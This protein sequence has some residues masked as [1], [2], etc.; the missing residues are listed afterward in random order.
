MKCPKC[1][2]EVTDKDTFCPS[3]NLRLVI[4]CPKCKNKVRLGSASCKACGYVFVKFCPRCNSANYV[5]SPTCRKCFY[6]FEDIKEEMTQDEIKEPLKKEILQKQTKK[7]QKVFLKQENKE[8]PIQIKND[9]RLEILIDF[10]NLPNIFKKFKDEEF[11]AKIL[12]NIKTSIKVAFGSAC[13]FYKENIARFKVLYNKKNN[14][15]YDKII[16]FNSEMDKLNSFLDETLN[17]QI[18]HKF[19]I[20]QSGEMELNKPVMQLAAGKEKDIITT[21]MAYE[22]LKD[23][24]S[25]VKISPDSYKMAS[26]DVEKTATSEIEETDDEAAI[27]KI[28]NAVVE[29]NNIKGISINS[30]RGTGKTY[31]LNALYK[32]FDKTD[33]A[34][35]KSR[36]SATSQVAPMG[37]FQNAFLNM[38]NLPT[39]TKDYEG[40]TDK[41][42]KMIRDYLPTTFEKS[43][44]E[45]LINL[46]YPIKEAFYETLNINKEKT[47]KDIKDILEIL[48]YNSKLLLAI[49]DFDLIDEMSFE[50]LQYLIKNNFFTDGSKFLLC[51][52]NQNSINMYIQ[53]NILPH[54]NCLDITLKKREIGSTRNFIKKHIGE[55]SICPRKISDQIIMNA[56]GDL[57]Y[58]G[59]VLYHLI[60]TK[61]LKLKDSKFTWDGDDDYFVPQDMAKIMEERLRFLYEKSK[62]QFFI[63]TLASFLGGCFTK[64]IIK[65]V[66][67]IQEEDFNSAI[68]SLNIGGYINIENPENYTFKNSLVWTNVYIIAKNTTELTPYVEALLKVL[69]NRVNSSPAICALLAQA[70]G[71]KPTAF[72]LWTKNLK[73]SS[74]IGDTALYIMSQKQSLINIEKSG[75]PLEGFIKN[76][77]FERL[78]KLTYKK[79]PN[80]AIEFLTNAIVEAKNQG[81][82]QK[83]IELSGYLIKSCELSQKYPAL[84]ETVDNVLSLFEAGKT[85]LKTALIKTRKLEALLNTGN[86]EEVINTVNTEINPILTNAVKSYKKLPYISKENLISTRILSN[87][88]LTESYTCQGNPLSFEMVSLIE[89]ELYKNDKTYDEYLAKKLKLTCALSYSAKGFLN[90][91]DEILHTLIKEFSKEDT[92]LISKWNMITIFNK[93]LRL[94]FEN[95]KED[96]FEAVTY[97]N[98]IGD[99]YTK[100]ILKTILAYV[101][102]EENDAL[103]AL[104]ICREQMNYFS[105]EKIALGALI[106]WYISAIATFKISGSD[107]A[108][109]IC[110]KSIQ[111]AESPKINSIWFK[112]LFQI[113]MA[114][115]YILKDDLESAKMYTELASQDVNQNE[116][117]YFML[118]IVRLR[119]LILQ[120]SIK[121]A[122][123]AK[124]SEIAIA[125]I[126][127]YEKAL[128][129]SNKLNLDNINYKIQKDLTSLKASCKLNRISTGE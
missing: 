38:F 3:C 84:I 22:I 9:G 16:K 57:A 27:N 52:R 74:A 66:I 8:A 75:I 42:R 28:F 11:K 88:I 65:E 20:L 79:N 24:I 94:D 34:I 14:T 13:E 107:R 53:E 106:S 73:L 67:D 123:P 29:E 95:I 48:R 121:N 49:D 86:Y 116:L 46:L 91:S 72:A 47:F 5:S 81:N 50:F 89:K 23:E 77:I 110:E 87:I 97:A 30:P 18:L 60:E 99:N 44:I 68:K 103:H 45:T 96:L 61:K 120:E 124:K 105:N 62:D 108:I 85:E 56:K 127:T 58:T 19:V 83:T 41:L 93:V 115:C 92:L 36:C 76:N 43:K 4:E 111:I 17:T 117:N 33:I 78:G 40:V 64:T 15:I 70:I 71:N 69:L 129:L 90:Q 118:Q 114:K 126:H 80:E 21:K 98:N 37:L 54:E 102:L 2:T 32:K 12:L 122:E 112:V 125:A 104:E 25:L 35:I 51:Y 100:N 55:V 128:S 113:F 109:E 1:K 82:S 119:A 10:I 63:L 6:V 39:S 101:I 26:F 59:Q 7:E 31:I